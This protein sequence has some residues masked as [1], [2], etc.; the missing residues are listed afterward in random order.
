MATVTSENGRSGLTG[1]VGYGA[2]LGFGAAAGLPSAAA[3]VYVGAFQEFL[4]VGAVLLLLGAGVFRLV[5]SLTSGIKTIQGGQSG[6]MLAILGVGALAMATQPEIVNGTEAMRFSTIFVYGA[7]ATAV[8]A[9]L[10]YGARWF[11]LDRLGEF[12]PY[13]VIAGFL[14]SV[15]WVLFVAALQAATGIPLTLQ[16]LHEYWDSTIMSQVI[17]M[18]A[19]AILIDQVVRRVKTSFSMPVALLL[20][21]FTFYAVVF[22]FGLQIEDLRASGWLLDNQETGSVLD[23]LR[24]LS[25]DQIAFGAILGQMPTILMA[26][27]MGLI[28]VLIS[29]SAIEI[30]C[31]TTMS[32]KTELDAVAHGN[33]AAALLGPN[34]SGPW[35]AQTIMAHEQGIRSR[36]PSIVSGIVFIL[37]ALVAAPIIQFFPKFLLASM[38]MVISIMLLK[39][40]VIDLWKRI[41]RLEYIIVVAIF[42]VSF[43]FG[44]VIGMIFGF[45]ICAAFFLFQYSTLS[46]VR[47]SQHGMALNSDVE[48]PQEQIEVIEQNQDRLFGIELEG[49]L[50]F[51]TASQL[52][53]LVQERIKQSAT[54]IDF[55]IIDMR[56]VAG[57]DSSALHNLNRLTNLAEQEDFWILITEAKDRILKQLDQ[58]EIKH[59]CEGSRVLVMAETDFALE[60]VEEQILAEHGQAPGRSRSIDEILTGLLGDQA[61]AEQLIPHLRRMDLNEGDLLFERGDDEHDIYLIQEGAV[62][63][64][65][66]RPDGSALR[67]RKFGPGATIGI[68]DYYDK[69]PRDTAAVA[70][71]YSVVFKLDATTVKTLNDDN[72]KLAI[73]LHEAMGMQMAHR[74]NA[75]SLELWRTLT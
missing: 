36:V 55:L 54:S 12:I 59:D 56:L 68:T 20:I 66:P 44:V 75:L 74:L 70:E 10:L 61:L 34:P 26:S 21:L 9:L 22:A 40:W 47:A 15:G 1:L 65:L 50:F 49:Y 32:R 8:F 18:I 5:I 3:I 35:D 71:A 27:A 38:V 17:L 62:S 31:R 6:E 19:A 23:V 30:G 29:F 45:F 63:L 57:A 14:A 11:G 24:L 69:D 48:R 13:P 28:S 67:Q 2:T 60:W 53:G 41:E 16:H 52:F 33:V 42:V 39:S 43:V 7:T 25:V 73:A 72:P 58:A 51:G 46:L 4:P 37:L 64:T